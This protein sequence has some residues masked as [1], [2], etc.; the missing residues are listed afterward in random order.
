MENSSLKHEHMSCR[1]AIVSRMLEEILSNSLPYSTTPLENSGPAWEVFWGGAFRSRLDNRFIPFDNVPH[2]H[3]RYR[4]GDESHM[5]KFAAGCRYR[6]V[7]LVL[8]SSSCWFQWFFPRR[9]ASEQSGTPAKQNTIDLR[10][11][12]DALHTQYTT[13]TT[14][15]WESIITVVE[16]RLFCLVRS[17]LHTKPT[18]CW[19][20]RGGTK[21]TRARADDIRLVSGA[22]TQTSVSYLSFPSQT[23]WQTPQWLINYKPSLIDL[24]LK[25]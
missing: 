24:P 15:A 13:T 16:N 23:V 4:S 17:Y 6:S 20:S 5:I 22:E 18:L 12:Q 19:P 25:R 10:P 14:T 8:R 7:L 3:N 2:L 11:S 1:T 9:F 21:C